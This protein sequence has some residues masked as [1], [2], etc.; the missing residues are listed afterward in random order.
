MSDQGVLR[1]V[2]EDLRDELVQRRVQV[3]AA[4]A[5]VVLWLGFLYLFS[6][7]GEDSRTFEDV[8]R[9]TTLAAVGTGLLAV[10]SAA[11]R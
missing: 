11:A 7:V 3:L 1:E 8:H 5:Y 6:S 4:A 9:R 10:G 2:Y